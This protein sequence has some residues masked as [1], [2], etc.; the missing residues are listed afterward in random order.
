VQQETVGDSVRYTPNT[1]NGQ[2]ATPDT[3]PR[4]ESQRLT[5]SYGTDHRT[6]FFLSVK[7]RQMNS[8]RDSYDINE[9]SF[10]YKRRISGNRQSP[11][12]LDFDISAIINQSS[13]IYKNS[14]THYGDQL[15]TGIRL[16][17]PR[18]VRLSVGADLGVS[19]S[20]RMRLR[21][22]IKSGFTKTS[23]DGIAGTTRQNDNCKFAFNASSNDGSINLLERCGSLIS[24]NR[25]YPNEEALDNRLGFSVTKDLSYIDVFIGSLVSISWQHQVWTAATGFDFHQYYRPTIDHRIR[26]NGDSPVTRTQSVFV[27]VSR[28]MWKHWRAGF[29]AKYQRAAFLHDVPF[30]YTALTHQRYQ[31]KS[32]LRYAMTITR[33]F[34]KYHCTCC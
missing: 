3:R 10:A 12:S 25:H 31:G 16:Q 21:V 20:D 15:I 8:L 17:D 28:G 29:Q 30:L 11:Y 19:M 6:K 24:Y 4:F 32:A 5:F 9:L 14:Y 23:H 2:F 27:Q 1:T 34:A 13:E 7:Q 22:A 18:D 26:Q 33:F